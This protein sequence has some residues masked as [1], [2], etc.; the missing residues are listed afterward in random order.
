MLNEHLGAIRREPTACAP[1]LSAL[2]AAAKNGK[3]RQKIDAACADRSLLYQ[4]LTQGDPKTR[5]NA[6]RLLSALG[7]ESDA[8]A[9][10]KALAKE[11]TRFVIPSILLALGSC[12]GE[13]AIAALKNYE[14]PA[15]ASVEEEKHLLEMAEAKRKALARLKTVEIPILSRLPQPRV[16]LLTAPRGF[17]QTLLEEV[18]ELE[19]P[20]KLHPNGVLVK[21][22]DL[23][24]V[25][26]ARCFFEALYPIKKDVPLTPEALAKAVQGELVYPYR[27]ELRGYTGDRSALIQRFIQL[28]GGE[29][30]PS[31]Y[32]LEVRILAEGDQARVY[33]KPC[34]VPDRRFA[35]RKGALPASIHPATA[36]ALVRYAA[37]YQKKENPA[38]LD[39]CCGSGTLLFER[40]LLSPCK[41]IFGVDLAP[42]AV[43]TARVNAEAAG[44]EAKFIQKD[45]RKFTPRAP[46]D[47]I[48]MN[49]PFGNRVGNHEN[50][51][52]LYRAL[53]DRLPEWLSEDGFALLYT[54]ESNLLLKCLKHQK[55][56]VR[57]E[58]RRTEAGGLLPWVFLVGKRS[59]SGKEPRPAQ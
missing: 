55:G 30:N 22:D 27:V 26:L 21:T 17:E 46:V 49:L 53:I 52:G 10:A 45:L 8:P 40:E 36:A 15:P 38:V 20:A 58:E 56:L 19:L 25:F 18:K 14:I 24:K 11:E 5:K 41:S 47:E 16:I 54:M 35:Y 3:E 23:N 12:G 7:K 9:L 43:E 44:S 39:A 28:A 37:R 57:L 6:A 51:E 31:A 59:E 1:A 33:I 32:G 42:N 2:V 29:N 48:Y 4:A 34:N 13:A 50:N